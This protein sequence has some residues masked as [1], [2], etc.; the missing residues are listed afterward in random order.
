MIDEL[1]E[2]SLTKTS[3]KLLYKALALTSCACNEMAII[4]R[5]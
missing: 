5:A 1:D 2:A 4:K 3:D